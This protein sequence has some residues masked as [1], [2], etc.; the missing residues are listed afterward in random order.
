MALQLSET[1]AAHIWRTHPNSTPHPSGARWLIAGAALLCGA[2]AVICTLFGAWVVI[3]FA[4]LEVLVLWLAFRHSDRHADDSEEITLSDA[5]LRVTVRNGGRSQT[6]D[7]H[8][9]WAQVR[10]TRGNSPL[11]A[12]TLE[13]CSHG[14]A[15]EIG[16]LLPS[17]EKRALAQTLRQQL[18]AQRHPL[19]AKPNQN[20]IQ[21]DS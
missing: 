20:S 19:S 17:H 15:V 21:E 5:L 11:L 7:F 3:P 4:G 2:I 12:D 16:R 1:T 13:I 8:P 14:R 18:A 6:E 10:F 9:Y